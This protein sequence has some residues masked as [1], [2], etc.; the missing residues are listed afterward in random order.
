MIRVEAQESSQLI[1]FAYTRRD[2]QLFAPPQIA[3]I[4]K[5]RFRG[6]YRALFFAPIFRSKT[7][8]RE[9]PINAVTNGSTV[10]IHPDP[11]ARPGKFQDH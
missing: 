3:S 8:I 2:L 5:P 7:V 6:I 1:R 11:A 4:I 9:L 10:F